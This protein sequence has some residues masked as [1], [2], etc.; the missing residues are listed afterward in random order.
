IRD[1]N[2]TGVQTCALP[3]SRCSTER[4]A[5]YAPALGFVKHLHRLGERIACR[6]DPLMRILL[7]SRFASIACEGAC[8]MRQGGTAVVDDAHLDALRTEV[9]ADEEVFGH[10]RFLVPD[11]SLKYCS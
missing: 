7:V 4:D 8:G 6:A 5:G 9:N 1:R 10:A 3:I 11:R 2:V